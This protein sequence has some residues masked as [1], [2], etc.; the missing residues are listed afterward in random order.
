M[1]SLGTPATCATLYD[2]R[3][4]SGGSALTDSPDA[5]NC[6]NASYNNMITYTEDN[7]RVLEMRTIIDLSSTPNTAPLNIPTLY[8]WVRRYVA[9]GDT[10]NVQIATENTTDTAAQQYNDMAYWNPWTTVRTVTE[11]RRDTWQ[12]DAISL[13]AYATAGQRIRVRFVL[14]SN[15][16]T[17]LADGW[18]ID[19]VRATY[20]RTQIALPFTTVQSKITSNWVYEGNWGVSN[21]VFWFESSQSSTSALGGGVWNMDVRDIVPNA[22]TPGSTDFFTEP[23]AYTDP[24]AVDINLFM[25]SSGLPFPAAPATFLDDY[26]IRWTKTGVS[27]TPGSYTFSII[28]TDGYRLYTNTDTGISGGLSNCVSLGVTT[29]KCI[30]ERWVSQETVLYARTIQVTATTSRNLFL[31]YFAGTGDANIAL[32]VTRDQF[33]FTDSPNAL[34]TTTRT[35]SLG[36][37]DSSMMI[38]GFVDTNVT[39][40]ADVYNLRYRRVYAIGTGTEMYVETSTDGGFTW[41]IQSGQTLNTPAIFLPFEYLSV[42]PATS[43]DGWDAQTVALPDNDNVMIRFRLNTDPPTDLRDGVYIA[44]ISIAP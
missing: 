21:D 18:Y 34:E 12:R 6:P 22:N 20:Q 24:V 44:D 29:Q 30:I 38:N 16:A 43:P 13:A 28:G 7:F 10:I 25:G 15:N 4:I 35:S 17:T 2:Y 26:S 19:G 9:N 11:I 40:G 14:E 32:S 3:R 5:A 23:I 37:G 39:A 1:Q 33:S 31:D 8:F 41:T 36:Y 27:L 42:P